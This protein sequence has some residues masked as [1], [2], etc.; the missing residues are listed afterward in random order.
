MCRQSTRFSCC[1]LRIAPPCFCSS[2][3][4]GLRKANG[5]PLC[6]VLDFVGNHR[7]EFRYDRRFR[8]L[9][10]GRAVRFGIRLSR[11]FLL[12]AGCSIELDPVAQDVV[13][14]SIRNAIPRR[15]V[16]QCA[17][18]RAMGDVGLSAYLG[19]SGLDVEDVYANN[20]SWTAMR[21][22]VGLPTF[23]RGPQEDALLRAVGRLLH[24][25]DEERLSTDRSLLSQDAPPQIPE[26]GLRDRRLL[27][28]LVRAF[29][30]LANTGSLT[31]AVEEFW[32]HPQVR[33]ELGELFGILAERPGPSAS[34]APNLD[35]AV[36][37][38][39]HARYSRIEILAA[40]EGSLRTRP[41]DWREGCAISMTP[42]S[43]SSPSPSTRPAADSHRP[44]GI[45]TMR[46]VAGS[47]IGRASQLPRL[48]ARPASATSTMLSGAQRSCYLRV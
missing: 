7:K 35:P 46:S 23:P 5:K 22:E 44:P 34:V 36:P 20:R 48:P 26:L 21:R 42:E 12:P 29:P 45:R 24:V 28:M 30:P 2:W 17:E 4:R 3:A 37:L 25:D 13:L 8:A 31:G 6:T 11:A 1:G 41:P 16:D 40:F 14:R 33:A 38:R 18:L 10:G 19:E 9:L 39:A 47:S 15:W 32:R 27:M 43:T